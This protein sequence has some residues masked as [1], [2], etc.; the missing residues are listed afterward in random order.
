MIEI[1]VSVLSGL[2]AIYMCGADIKRSFGM[3]FPAATAATRKNRRR[4]IEDMKENTK[5]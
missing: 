2:P 1:T 3:L 5:L 4:G